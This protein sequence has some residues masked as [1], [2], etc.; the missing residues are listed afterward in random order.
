MPCS[1]APASKLAAWAS[2]PCPAPTRRP[3]NV[4]RSKF[5][6]VPCRGL[7]TFGATVVGNSPSDAAGRTHNTQCE[8]RI[9]SFAPPSIRDP[10]DA[11]KGLWPW[12][13]TWRWVLQAPSLLASWLLG[14][15][16][17][18][19]GTLFVGQFGRAPA[20]VH[21]ILHQ[22]AGYGLHWQ[23]YSVALVTPSANF[24]AS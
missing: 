23:R 18:V 10:S 8:S 22:G 4:C 3:F 21:N 6:S 2:G 1:T 7:T 11:S 16:R 5:A 14:Q 19:L 13:A 15:R 12:A 24:A 17:Q 9:A 20:L